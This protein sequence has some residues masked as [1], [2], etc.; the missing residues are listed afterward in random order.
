M[1]LGMHF[2]LYS[3]DPEADRAFFRDVLELPAI[4]SGGG[5]LIFGLPPAEMGIHPAEDTPAAMTHAGQELATATVY[6]MCRNLAQTLERLKA[7]GVQHSALREA[8]WGI[9]SSIGLPGGGR[10]GLYE[11]H[12]PLAITPAAD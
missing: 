9:A 12:H 6:L 10:L 4:D 3:R 11:P 2:L 1:F 7:R 8:E 5:W